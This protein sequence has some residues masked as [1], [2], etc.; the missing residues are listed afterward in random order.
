ETLPGPAEPVAAALAETKPAAPEP[1]PKPATKPRVTTPPSVMEVEDERSDPELVE[2]FIEEAK[3]EIA[4]IK[5]HLPA[6]LENQQDSEA[7]ISVRRAFH[8][9]KGSGRMV[10]ARLIGE[11]AWSVENLLNRLINQTL[12]PTP[13]M[14]A[15]VAEAADALP[16]LIEQLEVGL[17]PKIDTTALMK[18]AEALAS[19]EPLDA[20]AEPEA[21]DAQRAG[22]PMDPVLAEIFVK[23]MRTHLDTIRSYVQASRSQGPRPVD[24]PVYRACHTLLGSARM[25]AFEPA[26]ELA[27]PLAEHM[28]HYYERSSALDDAQLAALEAAA[29]EIEAMARALESGTDYR[30]PE[31]SVERLQALAPH[32]RAGA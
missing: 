27:A 3:E 20:A 19:G 13:A 5:R 24:E 16:Q 17:A 29:A 30:L 2:L 12:E 10:G 9:L 22:P 21:A 31:G 1:P 23:E 4:N 8:T 11:F 7:L 18:R 14:L 25:A 15:F 26:M 28:R 32:A 6:W